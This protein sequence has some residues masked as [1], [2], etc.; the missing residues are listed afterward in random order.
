MSF[1]DIPI[2]LYFWGNFKGFWEIFTLARKISRDFSTFSVNVNI[3]RDG[4]F[5]QSCQKSPSPLTFYIF[6]QFVLGISEKSKSLLGVI[7]AE[8]SLLIYLPKIFTLALLKTSSSISLFKITLLYF[9]I[10]V[11]KAFRPTNKVWHETRC[12]RWNRLDCC[13]HE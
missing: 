7:F 8:M 5:L 9:Q 12:C 13:W 3:N 4:D 2:V 10:L 6:Y 1:L 11:F